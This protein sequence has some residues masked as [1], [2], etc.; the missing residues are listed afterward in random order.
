VHALSQQTPSTH[1]PLPHSLAAVHVV[2]FTLVH[3]PSEPE[4]L[5]ENPEPVQ[6]VL[7]QIP[8]TQLPLVHALLAVQ[9]SPLVFLA[10]HEPAAQ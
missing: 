7:Q 4:M 2:P 3:V 6:V 8:E 9:A 5:H 1:L 10:T